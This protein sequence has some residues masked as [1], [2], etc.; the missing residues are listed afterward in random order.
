MLRVAAVAFLASAASGASRRATE[1]AQHVQGGYVAVTGGFSCPAECKYVKGFRDCITAAAALNLPCQTKQRRK[2]VFAKKKWNGYNGL[3]AQFGIRFFGREVEWIDPTGLAF[4]RGIR[5]GDQLVKMT[6]AGSGYAHISVSEKTSEVKSSIEALWDSVAVDERFALQFEERCTLL[7]VSTLKLPKGNGPD[8]PGDGPDWPGGCSWNQMGGGPQLVYNWWHL[9]PDKTIKDM[10]PWTQVQTDFYPHDWD[11]RAIPGNGTQQFRLCKCTE[12]FPN[13][14]SVVHARCSPHCAPDY[15]VCTQHEGCKRIDNWDKCRAA[16]TQ[17]EVFYSSAETVSAMNEWNHIF[18]HEMRWREIVGTESACVQDGPR[19][20]G[21]TFGV[22]TIQPLCT[23][24]GQSGC[25]RGNLWEN[26]DATFGPSGGLHCGKDAYADL[27][28]A[29]NA[30]YSD[31]RWWDI[32]AE[33]WNPL[34]P[35]FLNFDGSPGG[36]PIPS[37]KWVAPSFFHTKN[38]SAMPWGTSGPLSHRPQGCTLDLGDNLYSHFWPWDLL[39]LRPE[40]ALLH[41]TD[42]CPTVD[43]VN[44]YGITCHVETCSL[45]PCLGPKCEGPHARVSDI[46]TLC[47][48]TEKANVSM[49]ECIRLD[50]PCGAAQTCHDPDHTIFGNYECSCNV[51]QDVAV[52]RAVQNCPFSETQS[53]G[54]FYI[55]PAGRTCYANCTRITTESLCIAA[56]QTLNLADQGQYGGVTVDTESQRRRRT[57]GCHYTEVGVTCASEGGCLRFN[58]L[59][60]TD[61]ALGCGG[62]E[63]ADAHDWHVCDCYNNTPDFVAVASGTC[64]GNC[65]LIY[66]KSDCQEAAEYIGLHQVV[67][68][69]FAAVSTLVQDDAHENKILFSTYVNKSGAL[70]S[71]DD[72]DGIGPVLGDGPG[73]YLTRPAGC[74]YRRRHNALALDHGGGTVG[75]PHLSFNPKFDSPV[76]ASGDDMMLCDCRAPESRE[77]APTPAPTW[78]HLLYAANA[79]PG[80]GFQR[81][82]DT[83]NDTLSGKCAQGGV[84]VPEAQWGGPP[85]EATFHGCLDQCLLSSICAGVQFYQ[86]PNALVGSEG[87]GLCWSFVSSYDFPAIDTV[88][89]SAIGF[90]CFLAPPPTPAPTPVPTYPEAHLG[91]HCDQFCCRQQSKSACCGENATAHGGGSCTEDSY[92]IWTAKNTCERNCKPRGGGC[93]IV[94]VTMPC[95]ETYNSSEM[96]DLMDAV[97]HDINVLLGAAAG[98]VGYERHTLD[99]G[100]LCAVFR[101]DD[102]GNISSILSTLCFNGSVSTPSPSNDGGKAGAWEGPNGTCLVL[103]ADG[104]PTL[105]Q[106]R[107]DLGGKKVSRVETFDCDRCIPTI[108]NVT[109]TW[110][111]GSW[112]ETPLTYTIQKVSGADI[113]NAWSDTPPVNQLAH[114]PPEMQCDEDR[115]LP[116]FLYKMDH[117]VPAGTRFNIS[118]PDDCGWCDVYIVHYQQPPCSTDIN[119]GYPASL[120]ADGWDARSCA[121]CMV[122]F[123]EYPMVAYRRQIQGGKHI[124]T[125]PVC[126]PWLCYF[127]IFAGKGVCCEDNVLYDTEEKCHAASSICRWT[128]NGCVSDWCPKRETG[129]LP[130]KAPPTPRKVICAPGSDPEPGFNSSEDLSAALAALENHSQTASG[131]FGLI[132]PGHECGSEDVYLGTTWTVEECAMKCKLTPG[133]STFLYSSQGKT[134]GFCYQEYADENCD[135][136]WVQGPYDFYALLDDNEAGVTGTFG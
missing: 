94:K 133:C 44:Q 58:P 91:G 95:E 136:G 46:E 50:N 32:S 89:S 132:K 8:M 124:V 104:V 90:D 134:R 29:D 53:P 116:M 49:D 13:Q 68:E 42:C 63:R 108:E 26:W 16:A 18:R 7:H 17:T 75:A 128:D 120:R 30:S 65:Q 45:Q 39:A 76:V 74:H 82:N 56:A 135:A 84:E 19:A 92:C 35:P 112:N 4:Y 85:Y 1:Q 9:W 71:H 72:I 96:S 61:E 54:R 11:K 130:P 59:N 6:W 5:E 123:G 24:P 81:V 64:P 105:E 102:C 37:P 48:C 77:Q 131:S 41:R 109:V 73:R 25:A 98:A 15:D 97:A 117:C 115:H 36:P 86:D 107:G 14:V 121:P 51:F 83:N 62:H 69:D 101:C 43:G 103:P 3:E 67:H 40:P 125:P 126:T 99:G 88:N 87:I 113:F 21:C 111:N 57:C 52:G 79:Y 114:V 47:D 70:F 27:L 118:C 106:P 93:T 2:W 100:E 129:P 110:V 127:N 119:A 20:T 122:G 12:G 23:G 28:E 10:Y 33:E 55:R 38:F 31:G 78:N 66:S 80:V 22:D 60:A 34:M